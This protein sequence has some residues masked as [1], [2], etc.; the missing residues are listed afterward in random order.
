[1]LDM[2]SMYY[3]QNADM[4]INAN[5]LWEVSVCSR[6]HFQGDLIIEPELAVY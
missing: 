4:Y 3:I 1:M 6:V 5:A 2:T